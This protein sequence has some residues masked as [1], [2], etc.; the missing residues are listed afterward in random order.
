[1]IKESNKL[2]KLIERGEKYGDIGALKFLIDFER[3]KNSRES[4]SIGYKPFFCKEISVDDIEKYRKPPANFPKDLQLPPLSGL[5]NDYS[6]L[7]HLIIEDVKQVKIKVS[8]VILTYNRAQPLAK[9]LA[10]LVKQNYPIDLIEVIVTDDGGTEDTQAVV[11]SFAKFLDIKY[12]WH[13]DIGFTPAAARN[14]GIN[15]ARNDFIILLDVDMM[16]SKDLVSS[17]VRY[18][19]LISKSVLIGPRKYIDV[20]EISHETIL[21]ESDFESKLNEVVTNNP[22]ANKI[23]GSVSVDWRLDIFKSTNLLKLEKV[24]FRV[25]ASGNVAFSKRNF[26]KIG[27]FQERFVT[28]GYE[29]TELGFRFF[30]DG[31]YMIPVMNAWAYH[32]EPKGG[33][34]ETDRVAGKGVSGELFG[35]LCPYYRRLT[36]SKDFHENPKVSIYIPAF[37]AEN[38]ICDAIDSALK[39]SYKD[40]EVCICDD[41]STD[42]TLKLIER[43]F[44]NN[45]RVR[46]I[47]QKNGGIGSASNAAVNMAKGIYVGQLDSDDYLAID[48]VEKCVAEMDKDLKIGLVYTSY[49]NE[50]ADG[51]IE[52]GYNYPVFTREKLLTAMIAHHFRMFRKL[53]WA[54]TEG[55]DERIKNAVDYDMYLKLSEKCEAVHLNVRGYRRRLHGGNTSIVDF[56]QQMKNTALVVSKSFSRSSLKYQAELESENESKLVFKKIAN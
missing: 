16:P 22:V 27:G 9:T 25:L 11:K 35:N 28:W 45:K 50:Y 18:H 48:V 38:T 13:K 54:R 8:I 32:Q 19:R 49:E 52:P 53:Y 41:G 24:P 46:W 6:Y 7:E 31:K 47:S 1:M 39:Q 36:T 21:S 44:S 14:N 43:Y 51:R 20:N 30:N 15:I 55:F 4:Y 5:G 40:L 23:N 37:N 2:K 56:K 29:D 34:N 26:L 12:V 33:E 10:G 17:Y 3:K 42:S